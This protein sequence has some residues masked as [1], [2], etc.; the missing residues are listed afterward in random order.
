M[1]ILRAAFCMHAAADICV[2][3]CMQAPTRP[4][5]RTRLHLF[6]IR[7]GSARAHTSHRPYLHLDG[8]AHDT[9]AC[10]TYSFADRSRYSMHL[11]LVRFHNDG[12]PVH[13][14]RARHLHNLICRP[15]SNTQNISSG[16]SSYRSGVHSFRCI[17]V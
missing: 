10:D 13:M 8:H 9:R 4:W 6:P 16:G 15:A 2:C 1:A 12:L 11:C 5:T 7:S 17:R 3:Q 14:K